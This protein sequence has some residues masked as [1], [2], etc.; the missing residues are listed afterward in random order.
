M[1]IWVNICLVSFVNKLLP[2]KSQVKSQS[3]VAINRIIFKGG[4]SKNG[5]F[6]EIAN[7]G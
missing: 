5:V 6:F 2:V 7:K 3:L 1:E 4:Q